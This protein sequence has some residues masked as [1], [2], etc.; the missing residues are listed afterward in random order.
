MEK[1]IGAQRFSLGSQRAGD[2][3]MNAAPVESFAACVGDSALKSSPQ[4]QIKISRK[5]RSSWHLLQLF[6][7]EGNAFSQNHSD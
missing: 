6:A 3:L 1:N 5:T 4:T 2:T 7:K